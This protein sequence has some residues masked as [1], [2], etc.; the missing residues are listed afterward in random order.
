MEAFCAATCVIGN[1]I[2]R[3]QDLLADD[4]GLLVD[5]RDIDALAMAIATMLDNPQE[6]TGMGK[7]EIFC[8]KS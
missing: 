8:I 7:I 5:V 6:A 3:I 4:C 2:R 1:K